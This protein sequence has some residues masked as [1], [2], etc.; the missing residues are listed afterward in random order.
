MLV[1]ARILA[2]GAGLIVVT[3][4]VRSA[5]LTVVVPRAEQVWLTR[6]LFVT[7]RRPFE[8]MARRAKSMSAREAI[9]AR[10]GPTT[11]MLLPVVWILGVML[12]FVPIYWALGVEPVGEVFTLSGSS[13][14]TLG[15]SRP[16]EGPAVAAS[17]I[18]AVVGLGLVALLISF[19]PTIY[20]HFSRR[21]RLVAKLSSRA[22]TPPTPA[23][24]L[25]R[26]QRIEWLGNL[27]EMW[28]EWE[29]W[30][31]E[32]E[33]SHT[34]HPALVHFRSID[35]ERSWITGAG[36]LLDSAAIRASTLDLPRSPHAELCIRAGYLALRSIGDFYGVHHHR[37]PQPIDPISIHRTEFDGVYD[38]LHAADI[39]LKQDRDQ[40]WRDFAGW[41]VNYDRVLLELCAVVQPPTAPWSSDRMADRPR[42]SL[43]RPVPMP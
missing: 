27:D 6:V 18:E 32:L 21:E 20:G 13:V 8:M 30:F 1:A 4:V 15:F 29:D 28:P 5:V 7:L 2:M 22:G 10:Y 33:E 37:D 36:A 42:M 40:A 11:L 26:H 17:V 43:R 31:I 3:W 9:R 24:L 41:R 19:L 38:Q 39:P 35:D 12:G 25:I 23:E 16:N 14:T 34:S